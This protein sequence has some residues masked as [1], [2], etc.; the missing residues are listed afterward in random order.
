MMQPL[1][2]EDLLIRHNPVD[3]ERWFDGQAAAETDAA[4]QVPLERFQALEHLLRDNPIS[5]DPY[6]ELARIYLKIGRWTDAKRVL[7]SAIARFPEDEDVNFLREEAQIARSL[8]LLSEAQAEFDQEPTRLTQER[9]NRCHVELNVLREK[10]CRSRLERHPTQLELN[11]PLATAVENLGNRTEAINCLK[12]AAVQPNLRAAAALQLGQVYERA[13][14][15]PEALSAYRRAAM[16]RVPEP[17]MDVKLKA[18]AAAA[19]LA[20]RSGLI[21]SALRYTEMLLDLQP[22]NTA[23]QQRLAELKDAPL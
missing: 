12:K 22:N 2:P 16:F 10:V 9:L 15:V 18:L 13:K 7:D 14:R 8:Q 6:L 23:I 5:V 11:M 20:Q 3:N 21:D 19:N 17:T 1:T 4:A